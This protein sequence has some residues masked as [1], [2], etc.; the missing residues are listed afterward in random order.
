[1]PSTIC[2]TITALSITALLSACALSPRSQEGNASSSAAQPAPAPAVSPASSAVGISADAGRP[3]SS[4]Q[5]ALPDA[6]RIRNADGQKVSAARPQPAA[7]HSADII[8]V[9][10]QKD[11]A[12]Q[13]V[14]E[15]S[16]T[17]HLNRIM[18]QKF[19]P[20]KVTATAKSAKS[21]RVA[22]HA[23]SPS[24]PSKRSAKTA[25]V[26]EA[27]TS[28]MD[29]DEAA[30]TLPPE[31][32]TAQDPAKPSKSSKRSARTARA[33][34][35]DKAALAKNE[36]AATPPP[37]AQTAA[38]EPPPK[39]FKDGIWQRI[40]EHLALETIEHQRI[41]EQIDYLRRHPGYLSALSQRAEPYLHYIV[42]L[43][44]QRGLPMDMVIVPM[45][46]SA[47]QPLAVSPKEAAG[48]WQFIPATGQQRG[49]TLAEGY[50]GRYDIHAATKAAL[51]H[52]SYL[53]KLFNGDWLL[54]LA[55]YNAGQGAVKRAIEANQKE[56]LGT[57]FWDLKLPAETQAY[58]PKILALSRVIADPETYQVK[59]RK[60][61][62]APQLVRVVV[63]PEVNLADAV[64]VTGISTEDFYR[65]NP[66]FKPDVPPPAQT[67]NLLLP[68][69]KAEALVD[70]L[71]G[72][73][74]MAP[75][76]VTVKQ[77]ETLA[78]IAQRH[79]VSHVKLAQWNK[80]SGK[81]MLKTGQKLIV[82][83]V[84]QG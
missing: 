64:T 83:P 84:S 13:A 70:N 44:E 77:G 35:A 27:D 36:A 12:T 74:L 23:A 48:L 79:G 40:R 34:K 22:Q 9:E 1:M 54:A 53:N 39:K 73:Q 25:P 62:N 69:D 60:I 4:A 52:L 43:I 50:D 82:Y 78:M 66:A 41:D 29:S 81:S 16:A 2:N 49:L 20:A 61:N 68:Q 57:T 38:T 51:D 33:S 55:A 8:I 32:Q 75:R 26:S 5:P 63:K 46:E 58:V 80:L 59:L 30:A 18:A 65:F 6:G 11:A 42:E 67:Y 56:A 28:A 31:A 17:A 15:E 72:T 76:K 71:P 37:A 14:I 45:V 21:L 47:F 10:R 3:F 7:T 19:A 24:K